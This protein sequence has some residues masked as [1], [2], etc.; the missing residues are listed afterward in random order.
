MESYRAVQGEIFMKS[1]IGIEK[2]PLAKS[3]L[4]S[5][6]VLLLKEF[7]TSKRVLIQIGYFC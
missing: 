3:S 2:N 5:H 1:E 4:P 7:E 6:K